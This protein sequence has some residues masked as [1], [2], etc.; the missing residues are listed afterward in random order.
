MH[1]RGCMGFYLNA[2]RNKTCMCAEF[3]PVT[4]AVI[5][6]WCLSVCVYLTEAH[7]A[8]TVTAAQSAHIKSLGPACVGVDVTVR[9]SGLN[10]GCSVSR[11]GERL[12]LCRWRLFSPS[13]S[14]GVKHAVATLNAPPTAA[15]RQPPISLPGQWN[16]WNPNPSKFPRQTIINN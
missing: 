7:R 8:F 10:N 15:V 14:A 16:L 4:Y 1:W 11:P 3:Q 9:A 6:L 12:C 5:I 13:T 2:G